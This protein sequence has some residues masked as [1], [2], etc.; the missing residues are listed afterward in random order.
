MS[1]TLVKKNTNGGVAEKEAARPAVQRRVTYTPQVDIL[2]QPEGLVLFLDMPGVKPENVEINFERGELVVRGPREP[3]PRKGKPLV[4]EFEAGEYY[5][6]F[7][8]S[9][10]VAADRITAELKNGVL[11]VTLP[12]SSAAL[13]RKISV[14]GS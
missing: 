5:R 12:K 6:A 11:T 13:P 3:L 14:K 9:Q 4:E 10:D 2:E 7:L 8:V 1:D